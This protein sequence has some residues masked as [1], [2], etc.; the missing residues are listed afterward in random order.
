MLPVLISSNITPV[1][2][3]VNKA[4]N[5]NRIAQIPF[6]STASIGMSAQPPRPATPRDIQSKVM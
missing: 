1:N 5:P 6:N 3:P 2:A 4:T